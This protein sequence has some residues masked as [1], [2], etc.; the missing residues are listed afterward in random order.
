V[1]ALVDRFK[2]TDQSF[3]SLVKE[4]AASETFMLRSKGM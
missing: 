1:K 4:I 2:T 3:T